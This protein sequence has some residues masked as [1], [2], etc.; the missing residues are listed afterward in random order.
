MV[1]T[2]LLAA[3]S[4]TDL[5]MAMTWRDEGMGIYDMHI[6]SPAIKFVTFVSLLAVLF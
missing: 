3:L 1:L 6:V 4:L 2:I 5:I